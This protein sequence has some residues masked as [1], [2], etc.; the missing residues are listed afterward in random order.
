MAYCPKCGIEIDDHV[1]TCPLCDFTIPDIYGMQNNK[2]NNKFP[3]AKNIYPKKIESMRNKFFITVFLLGLESILILAAIGIY[4]HSISTYTTGTIFCLTSAIIYLFLLMGY[5]HS[6]KIRVIL[7]GAT[8]IALNLLLDYID[9]SIT[10]SLTYSLPITLSGVTI[11][12]IMHLVYTKS[13]HKIHFIF[14]PIYICIGLSIFILII[15]AVISL[16]IYNSLRLTWS[17]IVFTSLLGFSLM[18]ASLHYKLP[19]MAKEKMKRIFH[20]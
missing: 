13:K 15:E 2:E 6:I 16:N 9:N 18:L 8:T 10:W 5:I 4:N 19:E 3:K 11:F 1:K 20:V 14:I 7:F 17:L 12:T